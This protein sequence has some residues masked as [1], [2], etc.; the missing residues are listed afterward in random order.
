MAAARE[1]NVVARVCARPGAFVRVGEVLLRVGPT[2]HQDDWDAR[3]FQKAFIIGS[4]RTGTQDVTFFINQ[5]VELAVRAL[6]PGINDPGTAQLCIDRLEQ[7]LCHLAGRQMPSPVRHDEDG[8]VR[9]RA[10]PVTFAQ[11]VESA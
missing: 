11:L 9:V 1:R 6:S 2:P 4:E 3:P 8:R 5:L 10:R 7:A